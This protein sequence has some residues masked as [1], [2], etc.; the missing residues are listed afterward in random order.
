MS[1]T[2]YA[3]SWLY[4]EFRI[5][6]L[7]QDRVEEEWESPKLVI[8]QADLV[9]ALDEAASNI[10]LSR[11]GDVTVVHENDQHTHDYLE[12]PSMKKRDLEKYLLRRVENDKSFDGP[13]AWC[14]HEVKHRGGKQGVLLHL[15]PKKLVDDTV[16]ACTAVGLAPKSYVPLTEIVSKYLPTTDVSAE[17][18]LVVVAC[19]EERTEIILTLADG[20]VLFVRELNYGQ[21]ERSVERLVVDVNRTIRYARQ[22]L[23]RGVDAAWIMGRMNED[24][25]ATLSTGIE[26]PVRFDEDASDPNFWARWATGLSGKLSANFISVFTQ[27]NMTGDVFRRIGVFATA[28]VVVI[29]SI[30]T[31]ISSGLVAHQTDLVTK[32]SMRSTDIQDSI[33]GLRSTLESGRDKQSHL[34]RLRMISRN[35]PSLL[36]LHLSQLTPVEITLTNVDIAQSPDGWKVNLQGLVVGDLRQGARLLA[37]FEQR[38]EQP[39]WQMDITQNFTETWMQQFEQGKLQSSGELGFQIAGDIR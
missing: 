30:L 19:F 24:A 4:G 20:D 3:I 9:R 31:L 36:M 23:S 29:A 21:S 13:A 27:K 17:K 38:L 7:H 14:Y 2:K 8:S 16:A 10:D 33:E 25:A 12:I 22:Q 28:A 35:L 34:Q 18:L 15:L 26:I 1:R 39:P 37:R 5:A 6:R 32:I 11:R